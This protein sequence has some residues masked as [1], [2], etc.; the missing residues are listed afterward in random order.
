MSI[1][2]TEHD[3]QTG[4]T[5]KVHELDSGKT[6][7][8]KSYDAQPFLE[9]AA[10]ERAATE[11]QQWGN[12]FRKVGTV[13]M[14]ELATMLRQDGGLDQERAMAWLKANPGHVTFSKFLK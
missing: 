6:V 13:P 8:E 4:I 2:Y 10:A 7:I 12:G 1:V 5:S 14:A 9:A 3:A 11:G